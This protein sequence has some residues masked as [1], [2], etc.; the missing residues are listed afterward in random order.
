MGLMVCRM[1]HELTLY[2]TGRFN[3]KSINKKDK[4]EKEFVDAY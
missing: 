3:P 1:E 4:Q 2:K